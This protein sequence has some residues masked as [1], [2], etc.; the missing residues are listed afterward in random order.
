MVETVMTSTRRTLSATL[1]TLVRRLLYYS[2]SQNDG[3]LLVS[4]HFLLRYPKLVIIITFQT[5][6][7]SHRV[8][9]RVAS[10]EYGSL[11]RRGKVDI[12]T[13]SEGYPYPIYHDYTSQRRSD[14]WHMRW[15]IQGIYVMDR[16][17]HDC[18]CFDGISAHGSLL[19]TQACRIFTPNNTGF[20]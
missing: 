12:E 4:S 19:L 16:E 6:L 13:F 20:K 1:P 9:I 3:P 10:S 18:Y 2:K 7:P 17:C 14:G 15:K 11:L 8:V 5:L